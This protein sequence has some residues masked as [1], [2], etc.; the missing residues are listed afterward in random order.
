MLA[1][2][3]RRLLHSALTILGVMLVTFLL[4]R[5]VA[6]DVASANL[7]QKAT[8]RQKAEWRHKHGY[9]KPLLLNY[10]RRLVLTDRTAGKGSFTV[11]DPKGSNV[12]NALALVAPARGGEQG[13][14]GGARAQPGNMLIGR[15]VPMLSGDTPLAA[16]TG[17]ARLTEDLPGGR[18]GR[19][20]LGLK[21]ADGNSL[22]VDVT[23]AATCGELLRR[24]NDEPNAAGRVSAGI[25]RR[26][27]WDLF[28]SQFFMHLVDSATFQ[29]R[30]LQDN[31][32]LTTIIWQHAPASLALTVPAMAIGWFLDLIVAC[33]VAY[34]RGRLADKIGVLLSV[35]GMCIPF[36]AF[37]IFGQWLMFQI[38]PRHAYGVFYRANVYVPVAIM[39][40][41]G[42]GASVRFYRTV[43]LDETN[44]DY[45]RTARAKGLPLPAVLFKHILRNCMLPVLTNL[46][47]AIPFLIMGS[48]LVET[49]FGIPGLGDLL[50]TSI[51]TRNEP[52]LSGMVF[53]TALIYTLGVLLT[54]LSYPLFDP[55]VRLG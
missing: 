21:L 19:A 26:S 8:E 24:I 11:R 30:S 16:L 44:R 51:N 47:L 20:V 6:A 13:A 23:G 1:Y 34:Y 29:G 32:K 41:A 42:M 5:V 14:E 15:F 7:G 31:R 50:L 27:P 53:L 40:V 12:S 39:V 17:G 33:L 43:I 46:I 38:S 4:F 28:D 55:R 3:L 36:L 52:I 25:S 35:L 48:L 49:Y 37:M 45:V 2:V 10:H 18:P 22:A 9:D 54:D